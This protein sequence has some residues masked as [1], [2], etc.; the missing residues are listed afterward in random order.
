VER[1]PPLKQMPELCPFP[2]P[3]AKFPTFPTTPLALSPHQGLGAK[4]VSQAGY[5]IHLNPYQAGQTGGRAKGKTKAYCIVL[6][7]G[8]TPWTSKGFS[9]PGV[10]HRNTGF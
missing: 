2:S 8:C 7:I 10:A 9:A 3:P 4:L 5:A 1:V 6:S